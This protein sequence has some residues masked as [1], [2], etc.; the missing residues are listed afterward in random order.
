MIWIDIDLDDCGDILNKIK[1]KSSKECINT[2]SRKFC[3]SNNLT[4]R[5]ENLLKIIKKLKIMNTF[6]NKGIKNTSFFTFG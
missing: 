1:S 3:L 5:E 6:I 4:T 2:Y